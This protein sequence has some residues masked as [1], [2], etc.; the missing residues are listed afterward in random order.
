MSS[1]FHHDIQVILKHF[2]KKMA[3]INSLLKSYDN[4]ITIMLFGIMII[5]MEMSFVS[6]TALTVSSQNCP[7]HTRMLTVLPSTTDGISSFNYTQDV[8]SNPDFY[9]CESMPNMLYKDYNRIQGMRYFRSI[10]CSCV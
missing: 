7:L 5:V 4:N 2:K 1:V 9:W 3:S 8:I 10:E 6:V